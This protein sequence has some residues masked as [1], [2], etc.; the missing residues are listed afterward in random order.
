MD[1]DVVSRSDASDAPSVDRAQVLAHRVVAHGLDRSSDDPR[2]LAVAALGIQ[3]TPAGSA[4]LSVAARVDDTD[5]A[6]IGDGR[7]WTSVW[8]ARGAPH[9]HRGGDV[10][11]LAC[12]LW[13]AD[14]DDASAR[15]VAG[16]K[17][18][19]N[20]GVDPLEGL[21]VT[22][23]ALASIVVE[24]L[25]KGEVSAAVTAAIPDSYSVW[26]RGCD[27][28]HVN[29]QLMRLSALPAGAR[30]V[31]GRSPAALEP[32][33]GWGG[34]PDRQ[35]GLAALVGSYLRVHGPARPAEVA[36]YLQ[37]NQSA[38]KPN[39]PE[40]LAEVSVEGRAAWV[41][42]DQLDDLLSAPA[43]RLTRLLP[44]GDPWLM[45]RD[46][47]LTVP[48]KANRKALW[49][50]IGA[51][52]A[53]LVDGEVVGTWRTKAS[54]KRLELTVDPFATIKPKIRR[55]IESE[56]ERIAVVRNCRDIEVTMGR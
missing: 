8:G 31:P 56:A 7:R 35:E 1:P 54:A 4:A 20:A 23:E 28:T 47:E 10:R 6:S 41:L 13:P 17:Q 50:V 42:A 40:D 15:L 30:L 26:C 37:T 33:P 22:A 3:D 14:G 34:V 36:A 43:P 2:D 16:G 29:E 19:R 52:G 45:A 49:P 24:A 27:A 51:P 48:D 5:D 11:A 12:A 44:R 46:R 25:G 53:V 18:L 21:R 32:I 39:W 38:I 9:V 55:E